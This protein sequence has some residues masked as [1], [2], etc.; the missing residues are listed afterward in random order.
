MRCWGWSAT[1]PTMRSRRRTAR[2]VFCV[3]AATLGLHAHPVSPCDARPASLPRLSYAV[4]FQAALKWHPDKNTDNLDEATEKFKEI[5]EA[6]TTLSDP[7]ERAWYDSHREQILR[8]GTGLDG[9]DDGVGID[10]FKYFSSSCYKGYGDDDGGFY[11]VRRVNWTLS[12]HLLNPP[13]MAST[14]CLHTPRSTTR[15]L[16]KSTPWRAASRGHS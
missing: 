16:P 12:R 14:N 6:H 2:Q 7:N 4:G 10:L 13:L 1:P 5:T 11:S 8:G 3:L 15:S 9:D